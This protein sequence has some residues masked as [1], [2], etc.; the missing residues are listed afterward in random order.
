MQ[1]ISKFEQN[2]SINHI[3]I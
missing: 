3:C 1:I 2:V